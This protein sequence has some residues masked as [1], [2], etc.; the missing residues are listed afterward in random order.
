MGEREGDD[1]RC[2]LGESKCLLLNVFTGYAL[3]HGHAGA[4]LAQSA[5]L[6]TPSAGGGRVAAPRLD[7]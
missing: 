7:V 6:T 2:V 3:S 4:S 5:R 1:S